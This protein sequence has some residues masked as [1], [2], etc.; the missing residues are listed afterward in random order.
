M[1]QGTSRKAS[2]NDAPSKLRL[3]RRVGERSTSSPA[4]ALRRAQRANSQTTESKTAQERGRERTRAAHG[5]SVWQQSYRLHSTF[6]SRASEP[7]AASSCRAHRASACQRQPAHARVPVVS[8][9]TRVRDEAEW[10][11]AANQ[12]VRAEQASGSAA[13]CSVAARR[14]RFNPIPRAQHTVKWLE[15]RWGPSLLRFLLFC[16]HPRMNHRSW[17]RSERRR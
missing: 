5:S 8:P 10:T 14:E 3:H 1:I 9:G 13:A 6:A 4:C 15:R 12:R 11:A 7:S 2:P 17:T 16:D